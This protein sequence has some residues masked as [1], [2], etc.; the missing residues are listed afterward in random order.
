MGFFGS[1]DKVTSKNSM[2]KA[3][4]KLKA[5][6][7]VGYKAG[8]KDRFEDEHYGDKYMADVYVD[9]KN[10]DNVTMTFQLPDK[11]A[12]DSKQAYYNLGGDVLPHGI[13]SMVG[14][15]SMA[16][17]ND[18]SATSLSFQ[19]V[20][21][22]KGAVEEPSTKA[23]KGG[24]IYNFRL[25]GKE[26]A[27]AFTYINAKRAHDYTM[28][29]NSATFASHALKA[30]GLN[31]GIIGG[32]AKRFGK[33]MDKTI[34]KQGVEKWSQT[35]IKTVRGFGDEHASAPD[36]IKYMAKSEVDTRRKGMRLQ[37]GLDTTL[38]ARQWAHDG[39][40]SNGK[41]DDVH[42]DEVRL[43]DLY[44]KLEHSDYRTLEGQNNKRD[45]DQADKAIVQQNLEEREASDA[46]VK[47]AADR[48]KHW[49][50]LASRS[51][52]FLMSQNA[53][54]A[55]LLIN[56]LDLCCPNAEVMAKNY[57]SSERVLS[58][59]GEA[60]QM[61]AFDKGNRRIPQTLRNRASAILA[62]I[63]PELNS[64]EAYKTVA[65]ARAS[66]KRDAIAKLHAAMRDY[67]KNRARGQYGG[68]SDFMAELNQLIVKGEVRSRYIDMATLRTEFG[69]VLQ[70]MAY[71]KAIPQDVRTKAVK[72]LAI[73]APKMNSEDDFIKNSAPKGKTEEER[74][75]SEVKRDRDVKKS[76]YE[77]FVEEFEVR[78]QIGL[79]CNEQALDIFR[80]LE[81]DTKE[82]KYNDLARDILGKALLRM[83]HDQ[84]VNVEKKNREKA[85]E[86]CTKLNVGGFQN[87]KVDTSA[88]AKAMTTTNVKVDTS[89]SAEAKAMTTT[90]VNVDTSS[91]SA[92]LK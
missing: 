7:A 60:V 52:K 55:N 35:A 9:V 28:G 47:E 69:D 26:L 76:G 18:L 30:A 53:I 61:I 78:A 3:E 89:A 37:G 32:S 38:G 5:T 13:A 79:R 74:K 44:N 10:D 87:V 4:E 45:R 84:S 19:K 31:V 67:R 25:T 77:A 39:M 85:A 51:D 21:W 27:A 59:C 65:E 20:G 81:V 66:K 63:A 82:S 80:V 75:A 12:F 14:K 34:S 1:K 36:E 41:H 56:Y 17:F 49:N 70:E 73:I 58:A 48:S 33:N 62:R 92:T 57:L 29:F 42:T 46:R 72:L 91:S 43:G 2:D 23:L 83:A 90:N 24:Q 88:S 22:R 64:E 68:A 86:W 11:K 8:N 15:Q 40:T 54:T 6:K 50:E 71:T 16:Y